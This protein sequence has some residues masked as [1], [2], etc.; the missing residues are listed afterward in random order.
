MRESSHFSLGQGRNPK[1]FH[2]FVAQ[3]VDDFDGNAPGGGFSER[4]GGVAI[5]SGPG[6]WADFG[7]ERGFKGFIGIVCAEKVGVADEK[8][9]FVIV[10]VD[11]PAGN[12]VGAVAADFAGLWVEDIHAVDFDP[13]RAIAGIEDRNVGFAKDHKKVAFSGSF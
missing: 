7:F 1:H 8:T 11:E 4:A 6:V 2:H 10:S 3:M 13:D 12:A 5:Q 9:F